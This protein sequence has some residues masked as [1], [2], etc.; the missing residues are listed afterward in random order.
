MTSDNDVVD[1]AWKRRDTADNERSKGAPIGCELGAISVYAVELVHIHDRDV[2]AADD[3][4][5]AECQSPCTDSEGVEDKVSLQGEHVLAD[6]DAG[7]WPQED[8]ITTKEGEELCSRSKDFP[9]ESI[10]S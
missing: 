5:A 1:E 9:L 10:V 3:I 4:V 2:A 8:R 6:Q 7:H